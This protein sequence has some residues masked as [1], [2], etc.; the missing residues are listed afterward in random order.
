MEVGR[1]RAGL[2]TDCISE[3]EVKLEGKSATV[4]ISMENIE[5]K[6]FAFDPPSQVGPLQES[7]FNDPDPSPGPEE[8]RTTFN[9]MLYIVSIDE[10]RYNFIVSHWFVIM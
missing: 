6:L 5:M 1:H 4:M 10:A 3:R 7:Q 9:L 2:K 8:V